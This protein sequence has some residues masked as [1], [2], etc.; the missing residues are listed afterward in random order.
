MIFQGDLSKYHPADALMFLSQLGLNGVLS[1]AHEERVLTLSFR[2][3]FLV[4]AQS[5]QADEKVLRLLRCAK[6]IDAATEERIRRIRSETGM[7]AR[8]IVAE[9][10][11]IALTDIQPILKRGIQEVLLELFL[12]E[13]GS[14]HFTDTRV[15]PDRAGI[16]LDTGA[17][18]IKALSHADEFRNFEKAIVTLDRGVGWHAPAEIPDTFSTAERAI[19]RLAA[20]PV[21]VRRLLALAPMATHDAMRIVERLLAEGTL[22]VLPV[23]E[24]CEG[25]APSE[26][27]LDPLFS[28]YKQALKMV[29][30][31]EDVLKRVEAVIAFCKK[32]YSGILIVSAKGG[33]VIH[34]K[35]ISVDSHGG[36]HQKSIKG[37]FGAI[38][39]DLVFDA[40]HRSGIGFFG[41]IFPSAL[42]G[43]VADVP[44][45]GEC[46]L[47]PIFKQPHLS[48]F[49]YVYTAAGHEGLSPHHYLELLS[50]M[51]TPAGQFE[52][53]GAAVAVAPSENADPPPDASQEMA[54]LV[55]KIDE[56]PPLPALAAR[57]LE[58]LADPDA[59]IQ[60]VEETIARDQALVAKLIKVSNSAL[61]G[62]LQKVGTL[63]QALTRLGTKTTRS[64]ILAASARGYFL[65]ER[66]GMRAWGQ[67]LWQHSVECG[68]AARR[69]AEAGRCEDPEEA[70]VAGI[71]HDIGK[72]ALIMLDEEKYRKIQQVKI[73]ESL[74]DGEAEARVIGMDH[75]ALGCLLMEKW[76]MPESIG[77]CTR[78]HHQHD[79]AGAHQV[80]AAIVAYGNHLSHILGSRPRMERPE[81]ERLAQALVGAIGLSDHAHSQVLESVR[82]DFQN[83]D[84]LD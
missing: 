48:M 57:T 59:S 19:A 70:F 56:L 55:A 37:D 80:L 23:P 10:D 20:N 81:N 44:S 22:F 34:C 1:V 5:A 33:R 13:N 36:I 66:K 62:G 6:H 82:L 78:W 79:R 67:Y 17:L 32:Y 68:V 50:W 3:G 7:A 54:R 21:T 71:M 83:T 53:A 72:L 84:L 41:R 49:L 16:K 69:I 30:R 27:G 9:L 58:L 24:G 31:A 61:Y 18:S 14:F 51:I 76:R 52:S 4:E 26:S 35:A 40:V 63:R 77:H 12:L 75:A 28:A 47:L 11:L 25:A 45:T 65:K 64:L 38:Q 2:E 74:S 8:Q 39:Q 60:S 73:A 15:D 43:R 29:L 42:I 46:A